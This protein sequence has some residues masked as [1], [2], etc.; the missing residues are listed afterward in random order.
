[1]RTLVGAAEPPERDEP[2]DEATTS[3]TADTVIEFA[4]RVGT[5]L[6]PWQGVVVREAFRTRGEVTRAVIVRAF[7][8]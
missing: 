1:M 8:V 5:P 7:R 2:A 3:S 4:A 6:T